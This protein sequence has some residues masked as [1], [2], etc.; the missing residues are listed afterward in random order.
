VRVPSVVVSPWVTKGTVLKALPPD[1]PQYE[2]S[3]IISTVIHKLFQPTD[4]NP[5][6]EYLNNRDAWARTFEAVFDGET[7]PRTDC[8]MT[9]PDVLEIRKSFPNNGL[10]P[11]GGN[12]LVSHLQLELQDILAAATNDLEYSEDIGK[13]WTE[14]EGATWCEKKMEFLLKSV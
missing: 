3:S 2:H 14:A 10:P 1:Q 12:S 4:S 6:P 9:L 8:P 11:V 7:S 13:K 5:A